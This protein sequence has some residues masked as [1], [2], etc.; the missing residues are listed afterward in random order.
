MPDLNLDDPSLDSALPHHVATYPKH[1]DTSAASPARPTHW[2]QP[3]ALPSASEAEKDSMLESM[4]EDTG[5]LDIDDDGHWDFHGHSSGRAF[6]GRMREQFGTLMGKPKEYPMPSLK[7]ASDSPSVRSQSPALSVQSPA[8]FKS[9]HPS[10]LPPRDVARCL[11]E[12]ALDDACAILRFIHQPTFYAMFD[13]VYDTPSDHL[14]SEESR[15]LP[16]LYSALALGTL[17]STAEQSE[18]MT[19]GFQNAIQQG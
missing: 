9:P 15:F 11:C 2:P 8:G 1:E 12:N 10:D 18:L 6:L 16:L 14:N 17:F 13:R 5:M 3:Q 7:A 4:V 19:N